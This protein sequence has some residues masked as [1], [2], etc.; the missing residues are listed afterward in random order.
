[1]R[2]NWTMLPEF[3]NEH[4][5]RYIVMVTTREEADNLIKR[6][7]NLCS[8][9]IEIKGEIDEKYK[10]GVYVDDSTREDRKNIYKY[11][12]GE[13]E[14]V[15]NQELKKETEVNEVISALT[16]IFSAL[17]VEE[18]RYIEQKIPEK[19]EVL[20]KLT[21]KK[22]AEKTQAIPEP[23]KS[24]VAPPT[25][26]THPVS[27]TPIVTEEVSP[28]QGIQLSPA[29]TTGESLNACYLY[30]STFPQSVEKFINQLT[31]VT[32]KLMK[33]PIHLEK[34]AS[35]GY[36]SNTPNEFISLVHEAKQKS[37]EIIFVVIPDGIDDIRL[38]IDTAC[39]MN[40]MLYMVAQISQLDKR[41]VFVDMAIELLLVKKKLRT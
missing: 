38:F 27:P 16:D 29:K 34:I 31:T 17:T 12:L 36:S 41:F 13:L 7:P 1:M 10:W 5:N 18:Q 35:I 28:Q 30:P 37:A 25:T 8:Q 19:I 6:F 22:E 2:N 14:D 15:V 3:D 20:E 9:P 40:D 23:Q 24:P 39:R 11:F 26:P 32:E 4:Q 21:E 33:E